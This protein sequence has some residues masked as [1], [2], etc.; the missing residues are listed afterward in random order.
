[1]AYYA[2]PEEITGYALDAE[3]SFWQICLP[4]ATR[5]LFKD[6]G[7]E[8]G[9]VPVNG[10]IL[11]GGMLGRHSLQSAFSV[12]ASAMFL[13]VTFTAEVTAIHTVSAH[14]RFA[15]AP[16]VRTMRIRVIDE[17]PNPDVEISGEFHVVQKRNGWV[18]LTH[19]TRSPLT[20]GVQYTMQV[21]CSNMSSLQFFQVDCIQAEALPYATTYVDGD[22]AIYAPEAASEYYWEGTPYNSVSVRTNRTRTGGK[23]VSLQ[24]YGFRTLSIG[25]LGLV[26]VEREVQRRSLR[27]N[28][29]NN[30]AAGTRELA[31]TGT[32]YGTTFSELSHKR[33]EFMNLFS[34]STQVIEDD[35]ILLRIQLNEVDEPVDLMVRYVDGMEGEITNKHQQ[36]ISLRLTAIENPYLQ[37]TYQTVVCNQLAGNNL[38]Q[39]LVKNLDTGAWT[40]YRYNAA[41]EGQ[42]NDIYLD[43][44]GDVYVCGSMTSV[45]H[46]MTDLGDEGATNVGSNLILRGGGATCMATTRIAGDL[47]IAVGGQL[48][49][50]T[51]EVAV[52]IWRA[53]TNTWVT[54]LTQA[55][56]GTNGIINDLAFINNVL[57][58]GG[59]FVATVA[60][61]APAL[62]S[63]VILRDSGLSFGYAQPVVLNSGAEVTALYATPNAKLYIGGLWT[64][65]AYV[66]QSQVLLEENVVSGETK[67]VLP[68]LSAPGKFQQTANQ[69]VVDQKNTVYLLIYSTNGRHYLIYPGQNGSNLLDVGLAYEDWSSNSYNIQTHVAG[70][71][72][73]SMAI[74]RLNRMYISGPVISSDTDA[75]FNVPVMRNS[76]VSRVWSHNFKLQTTPLDAYYR[77]MTFASGA[78]RRYP[79]AAKGSQ[80]AVATHRDANNNV[81][82]GVPTQV[83][84]TGSQHADAT[85]LITGFGHFIALWN[86][87]TGEQLVLQQPISL[88]DKSAL[89]PTPEPFSMIGERVMVMLRN[90]QYMY[91]YLDVADAIW[92]PVPVNTAGTTQNALRLAPGV[93]SITVYMGRGNASY[94]LQVSPLLVWRTQHGAL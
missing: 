27:F 8:T 9:I 69:I 35:P 42:I 30:F 90:N 18:R 94:G 36:R 86:W 74:D 83:N 12:N 26:P 7:F 53:S 80:L 37:G 64:T 58:V 13:N 72:F 82:W 4:Q 20:A 6:P 61:N 73:S 24:D 2:E 33:V 40:P 49:I 87:T 70:N 41:T 51:T 76:V 50:G 66:G 62:I 22:M 54:V 88:L 15:V 89:T 48:T 59:K 81:I 60:N 65:T 91:R 67:S 71:G 11:T 63:V 45:V 43:D 23:L 68:P 77:S 57:Y 28:R 93:N 19:T 56:I 3:D 38:T 5:N 78:N 47:W 29:S 39:V 85:L 1:M 79:L 21:S 52:A 31:I 46:K 44:N 16:F 25:G 17:G 32:L 55:Q 10:T 75:L 34:P 92:L 14:V 84:N